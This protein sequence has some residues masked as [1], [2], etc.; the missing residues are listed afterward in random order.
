MGCLLNLELK[1]S[2]KMKIGIITLFGL[3]NNGNRLQN[4]AVTELLQRRGFTV[5]SVVC[6]KI[7]IRSI[8]NDLRR[9]L[10]FWSGYSKRYR[11]FKRWNKKYMKVRF[12]VSQN[13][14]MPQRVNNKYD[15]FVVGSDQVWNPEIRQ[16]ERDTFFLKFTNKEKRVCLSPSIGV[17]SI[18]NQYYD[19]YKDGLSGFNYLSCREEDGSREISR[20]TGKEC[21]TLI[22]P[23]LALDS[24]YWR[25][26]GNYKLVP[27]NNFLIQ[28]FLSQ[29]K[30]DVLES[31]SEYAK[32]NNY[33]I[34]DLMDVES[35]YY[36]QAPDAFISLIDKAQIV[37]TD[38][39]HAVAFSVNLNTPF[40]AF[41]RTV[42]SYNEGLSSMNSRI[43]S[44][45]SKL[46][47]SNRFLK[48]PI[49][50]YQQ[51]LDFCKSNEVLAHCR[52]DF[53]NYL[54]KVLDKS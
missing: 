4:L 42:D 20:I 54:S 19:I 15:I 37:F 40:Y 44:L 8:K 14:K 22:D 41:D 29:P 26:V 16:N 3:S 21:E 10:F 17:S 45:L 35:P 27:N 9:M 53:N 48:A 34:I 47:L 52:Y 11:A 13:L 43:T 46:Y 50:K 6:E 25:S 33:E 7:T 49:D 1:S 5:E 32:C 2:A 23:S 31:I 38:S 24:D 30:T 28:L 39:F 36:S 12:F 18:S 51:S